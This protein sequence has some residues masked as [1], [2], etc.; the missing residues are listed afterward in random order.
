MDA[1]SLTASIERL[2]DAKLR[3]QEAERHP[4]ST[5][6]RDAAAE[7]LAYARAGLTDDVLDAFKE[8]A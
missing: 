1:Q 4:Q 8:R 6:E 2:I 5:R 7:E 3:E